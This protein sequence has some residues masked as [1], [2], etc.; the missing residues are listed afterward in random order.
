MIQLTSLCFMGLLFYCNEQSLFIPNNEPLPF[1]VDEYVF[2]DGRIGIES[3]EWVLPNSGEISIHL[4]LSE[5]AV[6]KCVT[7]V[8]TIWTEST[9]TY[10]FVELYK[11]T[12]F[13]KIASSGVITNN[14]IYTEVPSEDILPFLL[15]EPVQLTL[16]ITSGE[17]G[18]YVAS[19]AKAF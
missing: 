13:K 6:A 7:F 8:P 14:Y 16:R 3:D 19:E 11:L 9:N 15:N 17:K 4:D 10:C 12:Q 5:Y 2:F 1:E 18:I